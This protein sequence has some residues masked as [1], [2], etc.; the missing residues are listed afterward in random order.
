MIIKNIQKN[1]FQM[2]QKSKKLII[3][4]ENYINEYEEM[5]MIK[6][7]IDYRIKSF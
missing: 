6:I 3:C 5:K 4:I 2:K 1:I 7:I